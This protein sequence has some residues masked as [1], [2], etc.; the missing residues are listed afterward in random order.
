[1][2]TARWMRRTAVAVVVATI[3]AP[4]L[5]ASA[6]AADPAPTDANRAAAGLRD[7]AQTM[8]GLAHLETFSSSL[9]LT[10]RTT[11]ELL[12]LDTIF[13]DTLGAAVASMAAGGGGT[14][15]ELDRKS[16]RLNSSH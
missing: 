7:F 5:D 4:F 11:R 12:R 16:T 3:A 10:R 9:P 6:V 13:E 15:S 2:S 14:P 1:M 8:G